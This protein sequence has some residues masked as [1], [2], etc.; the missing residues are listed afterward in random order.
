[1]RLTVNPEAEPHAEAA[2]YMTR[3]RPRMA[4][5]VLREALKLNPEQSELRRHL[6][7]IETILESSHLRLRESRVPLLVVTAHLIVAWV[8]LLAIL[9]TL[10]VAPLLFL[11][12]VVPSLKSPAA[13]ISVPEVAV[14]ATAGLAWLV[15]AVWLI[16]KVF[17]VCWFTYLGLLPPTHALAADAKLRSVLATHLFG[18]RY[19]EARR[20]FFASR[21]GTDST[22]TYRG[23]EA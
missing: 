11:E 8:C 10:L 3:G 6:A 16:A 14:A 21:Y 15:I 7:R 13:A 18:K 2:R 4:A 20:V 23:S 19:I 1:M 17:C 22:L 9:C 12:L 5:F